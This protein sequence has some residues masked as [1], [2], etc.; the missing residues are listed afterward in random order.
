MPSQLE[1]AILERREGGTLRSVV[2]ILDC[3]P[4]DAVA[5]ARLGRAMQMANPQ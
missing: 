2:Q 1:Q 4:A 3:G 5:P